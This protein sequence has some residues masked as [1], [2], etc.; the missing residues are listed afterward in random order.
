MDRSHHITSQY[1]AWDLGY[2]VFYAM[3]FTVLVVW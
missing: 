1:V 3:L 2:V